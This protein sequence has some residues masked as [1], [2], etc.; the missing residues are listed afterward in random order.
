VPAEGGEFVLTHKPDPRPQWNPA[1]YEFVPADQRPEQDRRARH[2]RADGFAGDV[3]A[4]AQCT[5]RRNPPPPNS[6]PSSPSPTGATALVTLEPGLTATAPTAC[7]PGA[8]RTYTDVSN[9]TE[10]TRAKGEGRCDK[11]Q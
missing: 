11:T 9:Y 2:A 5:A 1:L 7:A 8:P 3:D 6:P 10:G 4:D